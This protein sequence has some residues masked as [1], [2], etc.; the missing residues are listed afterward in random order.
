M[1]TSVKAILLGFPL[2]ILLQFIVV[3]IVRTTYEAQPDV[4]LLGTIGFLNGMVAFFTIKKHLVK[5]E[6]KQNE[7]K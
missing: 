6:S 4:R 1:N 7:T 2:A 3:F 5:K